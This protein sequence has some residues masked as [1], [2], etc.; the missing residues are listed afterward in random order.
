MTWLHWQKE[1]LV[2]FQIEGK[3]SVWVCSSSDPSLELTDFN[4]IPHWIQLWSPSCGLVATQIGFIFLTTL[5]QSYL[6]ISYHNL[7]NWAKQYTTCCLYFTLILWEKK[8]FSTS[9]DCLFPLRLLCLLPLQLT[10]LR[11]CYLISDISYLQSVPKKQ[12]IFCSLQSNSLKNSQNLVFLVTLF[13]F[14]PYKV[15]LTACAIIR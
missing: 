1:G 10:T 2:D 14:A 9:L 15:T 11:T 3:T 4:T 6:L 12:T 8:H 5:K 7:L 13:L